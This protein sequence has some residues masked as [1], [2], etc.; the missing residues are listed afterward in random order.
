VSEDWAAVAKAIDSRLSELGLR[1]HE[2]AQ[3]AQVSQAMVRELQHN[4][5]Q[6]RR[7]ARTL[8]ALS[9]ALGWHPEHL[10][11]VLNGG[12]LPERGDPVSLPPDMVAARLASIDHRLRAVEDRLTELVAHLTDDHDRDGE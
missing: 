9:V 5:A 10:R 3:R 4:T 7:N 2:L 11:A 8:E 1:Q 6:R 12:S